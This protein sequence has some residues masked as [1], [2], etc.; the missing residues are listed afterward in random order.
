MTQT[1]FQLANGTWEKEPMFVTLGKDPARARRFGGSMNAFSNREG[2][3][4]SYLVDNYPWE[5]LNAQS[6]LVVDVGG[7]HGFISKA[8]GE[9]FDKLKFVVQ[10]LPRMIVSAPGV[11][12]SKLEGRLEFMAHD[13]MIEQPV[14]GA[15]GKHI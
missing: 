12:G 9:K 10:D 11:Q 5:E 3:E 4:A 8:I 13:F 7:S 2:F 1:G 14:K 6:G 15:D